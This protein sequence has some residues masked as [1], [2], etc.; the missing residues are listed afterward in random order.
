MKMIRDASGFVGQWVA[1]RSKSTIEDGAMSFGFVNDDGRLVA[2]VTITRRDGNTCMITVAATDPHW[3]HPTHLA[4]MFGTVYDELG[5]DL[6][7]V[8]CATSNRRSN[9]LALGLGFQADGRLRGIGP[10]GDDLNL[11]GMLREDCKFLQEAPAK[12]SING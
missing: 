6:I 7:Y 3:C 1:D 4:S 10:N 5:V 2:G 11:Y 9:R 12:V 8:L